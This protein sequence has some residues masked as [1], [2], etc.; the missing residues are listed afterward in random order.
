MKHIKSLFLV[1]LFAVLVE[2][3]CAERILSISFTIDRNESVQLI[4]L[5]ATEGKSTIYIPRGSYS[6]IITGQDNESVLLQE[7]MDIIFEDGINETMVFLREPYDPD[8]RRLFLYKN[9]RQIFYSDIAFCDRNGVCDYYENSMTCPSDCPAGKNDSNNTSGL[10]APDKKED[11]PYA[12]IVLLAFIVV[13][14]IVAF[15]FY[16][17]KQAQKIIKER[18]DF[19]RWKEEQE[20]LKNAGKPPV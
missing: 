18:E 14:M 3:A 2:S 1:L 5:K 13:L 15:M 7:D 8:M 16:R 4:S 12:S 6:L 20:K 11:F 17:K 10:F 9:S 19:I